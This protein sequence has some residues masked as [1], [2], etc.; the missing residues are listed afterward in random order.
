MKFGVNSFIWSAACDEPVFDLLPSL[1]ERGFDGVEVPIFEAAGF[2]AAR[3]AKA[4]KETGLEATACT[5]IPQGMSFAHPDPDVRRR[6]VQHVGECVHA[7]A[8][9]GIKLFV[10]PIYS[11]VG[12]FTGTRRT[13]DEWSRAVDSYR[14][15]GPDLAKSGVT[16]AIEPLNR[17]ET[18]FLN[19][20]ED[21][22]R[23][24]LEVA[25]PNVGIL[26][27]TFHAHIEEFDS[28]AALRSV[29]DVVKHVHTSENNRGTPGAGQVNWPGVFSALRDIGYDGW[30]T[31]ESF[32]FALG[33]ISA[34]A[35]IW[36]DLASTPPA[37]AFD[38]VRFLRSNVSAMA[39]A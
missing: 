32:G 8:E 20:A 5:V 9:A 10:G 16:I 4:L 7:L 17:F 25:H 29:G 28:P 33:G 1:K 21:A 14:E 6:T 23:F 37:I 19:T 35:S 18:Y 2:P 11:P 27:D 13:A 22:R 26:F 12:F 34:A 39:P 15:L 38:G 24:V 30:L 3:L 31:I 36:R